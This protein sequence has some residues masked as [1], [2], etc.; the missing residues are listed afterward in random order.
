[1]E[2]CDAGKSKQENF[3]NKSEHKQVTN[4]G[5]HINIGIATINKP[6]TWM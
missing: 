6:K 1:M 2:P 5:A 4:K 3:P